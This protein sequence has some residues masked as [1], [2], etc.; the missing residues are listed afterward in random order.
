LTVPP[1]LGLLATASTLQGQAQ[2]LVGIVSG[3]KRTA[4][5]NRTASSQKSRVSLIFFTCTANPLTVILCLFD[6]ILQPQWSQDCSLQSQAKVE[7]ALDGCGRRE[8]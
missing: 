7:V 2:V 8:A 4:A 3:A 1:I 5:A 6:I